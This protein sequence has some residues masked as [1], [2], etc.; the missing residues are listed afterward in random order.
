[1][2]R[3]ALRGDINDLRLRVAEGDAGVAGVRRPELI[4]SPHEAGRCRATPLR[5]V[6]SSRIVLLCSYI[7]LVFFFSNNEH[8]TAKSYLDRQMSIV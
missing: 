1:M 3:A 5:V 8:A 7:F 6:P 2:P 4:P